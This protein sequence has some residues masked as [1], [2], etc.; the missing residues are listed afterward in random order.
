MS[1][2]V[3]HKRLYVA[4]ESLMATV[5]DVNGI[6]NRPSRH[7]FGEHGILIAI[8]ASM[9]LWALLWVIAV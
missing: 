8:P 5:L 2:T 3:N 7:R 9:A 6:P 4:S 1:I